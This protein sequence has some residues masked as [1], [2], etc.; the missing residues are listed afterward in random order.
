MQLMESRSYT[1]LAYAA[2]KNHEQCFKLLLDHATKYCLPGSEDP[3]PDLTDLGLT[4]ARSNALTEWVNT[5]T[6]ESFTALHFATY[7]GNFK[8]IKTMVDEMSADIHA[9]NMYGANVLHIAAQGDQPC[10]LYYFV[11]I[12][13]MDIN[14]F[15]NRGSTP[16]HWACY[17]KSEY[18]L[19]YILAMNPDLES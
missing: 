9:K 8:L 2:F 18:A 1:T 5:P 6:D 11:K 17:S 16:L 19:S 12:R 14:I 10:P 13:H 4:A 15:D 7:H 3:N